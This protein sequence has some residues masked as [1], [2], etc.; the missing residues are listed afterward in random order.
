M[1]ELH[2]ILQEQ[3]HIKICYSH[4]TCRSDRRR[5]GILQLRLAEMSGETPTFVLRSCDISCN[6]WSGGASGRI[7]A[8]YAA[9]EE[10]AVLKHL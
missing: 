5:C 1:Y 6:S 10:K 3:L 9:H 2:I 4:F 8:V 7:A